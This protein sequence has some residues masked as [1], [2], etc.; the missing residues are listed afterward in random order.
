MLWQLDLLN[1]KQH[2]KMALQLAKSQI[3]L[4]TSILSNGLFTNS[5]ITI[6]ANYST[7]G[8]RRIRLNIRYYSAP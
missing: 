8:V 4:I 2:P 5:K 1:N 7:R 6:V 3:A